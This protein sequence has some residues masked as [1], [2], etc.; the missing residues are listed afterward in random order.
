[1]HVTHLDGQ[2]IATRGVLG[3]AIPTGGVAKPSPGDWRAWPPI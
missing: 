1:M 2:I 3:S